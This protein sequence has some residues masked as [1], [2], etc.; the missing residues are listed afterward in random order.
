MGWGLTCRY[1]PEWARGLE[2]R[3][4]RGGGGVNVCSSPQRKAAF[5]RGRRVGGKGR[6]CVRRLYSIYWP[7]ECQ[8]NISR[9]MGSHPL[10]STK[11]SVR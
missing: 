4:N 2:Q 5:K 9:K 1:E 6:R 10:H 11:T 8:V 3:E 7:V